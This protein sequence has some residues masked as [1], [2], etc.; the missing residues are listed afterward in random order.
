MTVFKKDFLES[1]GN[2]IALVACMDGYEPKMSF[3]GFSTDEIGHFVKLK[4]I[5]SELVPDED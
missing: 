5:L 3:D 2:A 1:A 4:K